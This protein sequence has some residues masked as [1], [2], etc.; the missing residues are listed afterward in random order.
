GRLASLA[1]AGRKHASTRPG[2]FLPEIRTLEHSNRLA[3]PREFPRDRQTDYSSPQNR[4]VHHSD[5]LLKLT[6]AIIETGQFRCNP[7]ASRFLRSEDI[8]TFES[9]VRTWCVADPGTRPEL[10]GILRVGLFEPLSGDLKRH[11]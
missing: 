5:P 8:S 10:D 4:D 9:V 2:G 1:L 11:A 7:F 3:G 6:S